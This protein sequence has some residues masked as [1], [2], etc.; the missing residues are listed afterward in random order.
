MK[1][2]ASEPSKKMM[3]D[4]LSSDYENCSLFGICDYLGKI[5]KDDL[6]VDEIRL[7][8]FLL[9]ESRRTS[10]SLDLLQLKMSHIVFR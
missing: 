5:S 6:T 1:F 2:D 3:I 10:L 4:L 7:Q 9:Q 8:L